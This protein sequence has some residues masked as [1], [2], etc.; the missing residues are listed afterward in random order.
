VVN[1]YVILLLTQQA[2]SV[3][4]VLGNIVNIMQVICK[5]VT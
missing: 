3:I 5:F 1:L 4:S 2:V